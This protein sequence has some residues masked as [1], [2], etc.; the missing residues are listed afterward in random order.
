M[1]GNFGYLSAPTKTPP[2]PK[3][4][5]EK[6]E[7]YQYEVKMTP[8][9][10]IRHFQGQTTIRM[11]EVP[12]S[13]NEILFAKNQ[14]NIE[15]VLVNGKSASFQNGDK[16]LVVKLDPVNQAKL[17]IVIQISYIG[18]SQSHHFEDQ[19]VYSPFNSCGWM[20]CIDSPTG[21]CQWFETSPGQSLT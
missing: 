9:I 20:I 4:D 18:S 13:G 19:Y 12:K 5:R 6:N 14:L 11:P 7:V 3:E 8:N 16:G 10:A 1:K 21:R 17:P 2:V 15:A